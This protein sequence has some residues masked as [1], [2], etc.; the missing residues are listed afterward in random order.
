MPGDRGYDRDLRY[1]RS[2]Y[3]NPGQILRGL[4]DFY[5]SKG[6][7]VE[8]N[9]LAKLVYDEFPDQGE[10]GASYLRVLISGELMS[11]Y[12]RRSL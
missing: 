6:L 10:S 9:P 7:P 2:L 4:V 1:L 5:R 11:A 3:R 8:L 12:F